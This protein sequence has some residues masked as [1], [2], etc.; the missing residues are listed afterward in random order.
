MSVTRSAGVALVLLA[1]LACAGLAQD[2]P[3]LRI[4]TG[5]IRGLDADGIRAF[6]GIPYA[7]PPVG[8]LRWRP[9]QSAQPWQ[10][11]RDCVEF[12]PA[13]PQPR[14]IAALG[15][16]RESE[17][18]LTLNVWAAP[19]GESPRPV[20]VFF[21]GGGHTVGAASIETYNGANLARAGVVVVTAN[22]RL[23]PF[24]Y[25]AH[26][27]L[28]AESERNVSGNYGLLDQIAALRWVQRNAQAFGGDPNCV[29]IF[30]ESAGAVSACRLLVCP[31]AA[32][33]FHR[34]IAQSG[35]AWGNN[36]RLRERVG[37]LESAEAIGQAV[38]EALGCR[39]PEQ[40]RAVPAE[41]LLAAADP[42]VGLF[43][44]GNK[45]GPI[46]DG[47]LIPDDPTALLSA[48]GMHD[49]P[50]MTG[51]NADEGTLFT[52][53]L[54]IRGRAGYEI[55][56]RRLFGDRAED[57]MERFPAED[58]ESVGEALNRLVTVTAFAGPARQLAR[59]S[60]E[61][62]RPTYLYYFTR[63]PAT[64]RGRLLGVHHGL[65]LDYVFGN[66]NARGYDATDRAV[67]DEMIARWT[68]FAAA[69]DP[70]PPGAEVQWRPYDSQMQHYL[71]FGD[72]VTSERNLLAEECDLF[73]R[74]IAEDNQAGG[75][76]E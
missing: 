70:N 65:E 54:R 58:D 36:R 16:G 73:D 29:T 50:L 9:P 68:R 67:S 8:E 66:L 14:S 75:G 26:P 44:Q 48:G 38:A 22:Y 1:C 19:A 71:R 53:R 60:A 39:T 74:V 52:G 7:A 33:L 21:H 27:A 46:V 56:M 34:A 37:R 49:V 40:L 17:D 45:F 62:D 72:T 64:A 15:V 30:G 23:G 3:V 42:Q 41:R 5:T 2:G 6:L 35:A 20:M 11:V 43:G 76:A 47:W 18:C 69:G 31:Q 32:G 57:V 13:C 25:L 4:D 10:G 51:L 12:G 28:S 61:A 63:R 59:A 55:A 24:G